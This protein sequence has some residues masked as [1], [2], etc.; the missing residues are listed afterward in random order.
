MRIR[1]VALALALVPALTLAGCKKPDETKAEASA[2]PDAKPGLSIT[3]GHLVLPAVKGNPAAAYFT[4]ANT[5]SSKAAIG[6]ASVDGAQ[7]AEIHQTQ[8]GQMVKI[9]KLEAD[10]GTT[11]KFQPGG[12]HVM[13]FGLKSEPAPGATVEMT[14]T[15]ADGDKMSAPLT[16]QAAGAT[17]T[18]GG[19]H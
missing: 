10:P 9:D 12:L 18:M 15:F 5:S 4:L 13:V 16:V 2:A 3:D 6:A 19:M 14:L 11:L 8:G 17:D 7:S 1:A